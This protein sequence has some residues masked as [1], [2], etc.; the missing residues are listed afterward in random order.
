MGFLGGDNGTDEQTAL[1]NQQ[2][3][4]NQAELEEKRDAL[5]QQRL[6]IIRGQGGQSW[7]PSIN[8]PNDRVRDRENGRLDTLISEREKRGGLINNLLNKGAK[9]KRAGIK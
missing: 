2:I 6:E 4:E 1:M 5:Y 7:T 3:E 8:S 9:R